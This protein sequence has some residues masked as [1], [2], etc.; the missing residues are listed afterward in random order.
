MKGNTMSEVLSEELIKEYLKNDLDIIIK[1]QVSS[2]NDELIK[3]A[4]NGAREGTVLIATEQTAGKGR[5]GKT[6]FSPEGTGVYLSILLRPDFTPE[7]TLVFTTIAAVA[8]A[9]AIECVSDKEAKIKWVNDI[10]IDRKKVCGILTE[11]S[12]NPDM[13]KQ[14]YVVVGI[15]VNIAPPKA[16]FPDDIKNIATSVFDKNPDS[17]TKGKLVAHLLDCF[18]DYYKKEEKN[19]HMEEY[20]ERLI[21]LD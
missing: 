11:S 3:M 17:N 15:G 6:F 21:T 4:K 19:V 5:M 8:T 18:M 2:T 7:D 9:K 10:Y 16:G 13:K 12:L 14:E 1:N 20:N